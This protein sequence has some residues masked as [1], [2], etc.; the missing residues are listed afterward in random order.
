MRARDPVMQ[1]GVPPRSES[2]A[3]SDILKDIRNRW[4]LAWDRFWTDRYDCSVL[5]SSWKE[6]AMRKSWDRS[7]EIVREYARAR[8]WALKTREAA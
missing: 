8:G 6:Q 5:T 7:R 2:E 1:L 3:R 4:R